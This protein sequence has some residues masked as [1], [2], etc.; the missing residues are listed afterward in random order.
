M[1]VYYYTRESLQVF[2]RGFGEGGGR[3]LGG[4]KGIVTPLNVTLF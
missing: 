1:L 3:R 2:V 4:I